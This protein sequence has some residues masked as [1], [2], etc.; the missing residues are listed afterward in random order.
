MTRLV[1]KDPLHFVEEDNRAPP[2]KSEEDGQPEIVTSD[3]ARQ[4]PLGVP[5]LLVLVATFVLACLAMFA[6][7]LLSGSPPTH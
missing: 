5:V 4:G 2:S 3:T 6:A 1:K 7:W